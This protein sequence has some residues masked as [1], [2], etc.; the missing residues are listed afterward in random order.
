VPYSSP[1]G[2]IYVI[3][4]LRKNIT[5]RKLKERNNIYFP[6]V[7]VKC[8]VESLHKNSK[9]NL[10]KNKLIIIKYSGQI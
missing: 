6:T 3:S 7:M 9:A 8:N 4:I 2:V 10:V 5:H 1:D